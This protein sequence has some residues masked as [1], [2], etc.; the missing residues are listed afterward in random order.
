MQAKL[1][2]EDGLYLIHWSTVH[3]HRLIL[4]VAQPDP[5]GLGLGG[6]GLGLGTALPGPPLSALPPTQAPGVQSLRLR[7]FPI[8]QQDGAFVL[9]GW[10]RSFASVQELRGALR[11]CSLRAGD[12]CFSL[13]RCCLPQPGGTGRATGGHGFCP[14][15]QSTSAPSRLPPEISNLIIMRGARASSRPLNLSQLSFHRIHQ[16]DITQ[17][18][19]GG[20]GGPGALGGQQAAGITAVF[21]A[22]SCSY[23]TWARA[24]GPMS[25]RAS[26]ESEALRR[27]KQT[28][29][30]PPTLEGTV[31]SSCEWCLKYWTPVTMTSPW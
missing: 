13:R 14:P 23:P 6:P 2:P 31:G 11:G 12:D 30:T 29:G 25:M 1:Q 19:C 22:T 21:C 20:V 16:D 26:C 9:E 5:V 18:G 17:V 15:C 10:G 8:E 27:A 4:T 7:K 3:L 24:Q 28:A